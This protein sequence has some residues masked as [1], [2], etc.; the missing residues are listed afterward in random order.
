MK[1]IKKEAVTLE[2]VKR[3]EFGCKNCLWAGCECLNHEK[4][5]PKVTFDGKA[6]TCESYAYFD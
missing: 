4:Y 5:A 2:M 6:A 1:K 3:S